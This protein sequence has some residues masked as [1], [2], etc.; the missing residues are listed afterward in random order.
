VSHSLP[1]QPLAAAQRIT[2]LDVLRG[3]ALFG[4]LLMNIETFVGP[5]ELAQGINPQWQG[6]DRWAD[7][8][9]FVLVQGKFF[10]LF[11]LLF[12]MGFAVMSQRAEAAGQAFTPMYLRRSLTLLVIGLLH[13]SL[14]WSGDILVSYGLLAL[15]LPAFREAPRSWLPALGAACYLA[16]AALLVVV[17]AAMGLMGDGG[18]AEMLARV[19]DGIEAQR[20]IYGNGSWTQAIGLRLREFGAA[21]GGLLVVGPE[22]F[23]MFLLGAW[24]VHSG[25]I[26]DPGAHPRLHA[27]L[28]WIALP[29]GLAVML[30]VAWWQPWQEPGTFETRMGIAAAAGSVAGAVMSLGYLGWVVRWRGRLGWLAPAGRMALTN[31]VMQS[32]VCTFVFYGYGL[33]GY[34][35][36]GRAWQL[37]F[38]LALFA[39]QVWLS[40]VWLRH[41][42][43]GPLEW[44]WRAATYGRWPPLRRRELAAA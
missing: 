29:L 4:I 28:R 5:F 2:T 34:E 22:V 11:S 43:F 3:F 21:L 25:A 35:Q 10:T 30:W 13:V 44:L 12:G 41:F 32:L 26:A 23:G 17:F 33:G 14:V 37:V 16:A 40:T 19:Q 27:G 36:L 42:Q 24:F 20:Q 8:L 15:M 6:L 31:Y 18:K 39:L 7:A 1:L 9:V 38:A